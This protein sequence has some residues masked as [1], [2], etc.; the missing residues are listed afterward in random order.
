VNFQENA[1]SK[2]ASSSAAPGQPQQPQENIGG[3]VGAGKNVRPV[4][5]TGQSDDKN[6]R[7]QQ[8]LDFEDEKQ[9]HDSA[10]NFRGNKKNLSDSPENQKI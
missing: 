10:K 1:S 2:Q 4:P 5:S 9:N 8:D 6:N 3:K 7:D